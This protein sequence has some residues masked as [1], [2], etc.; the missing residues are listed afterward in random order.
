[1]RSSIAVVA[2]ISALVAAPSVRAQPVSARSGPD[3]YLEVQ[4]GAFF[5]QA[6]DIDALDPGVALAG[7]LGAMFTPNL[8]AEA[9][10]GYYRAAGANGQTLTAVPVLASLRLKAPFKPVELSARAGLGIH[11]ASSHVPGVADSTSTALG[12]HLGGAVAFN[13]SPT[14]QVGL[15]LLGTFAKARFRGTSTRLDGVVLAVKLGYMF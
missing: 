10:L 14:M 3:T 1:M 15:D 2:V 13:L 12:F 5:P 7:T 8:G 11:F 4:L 6:K 9:S